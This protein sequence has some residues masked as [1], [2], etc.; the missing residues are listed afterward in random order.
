MIKVKF[1]TIGLLIMLTITSLAF[2]GCP[3]PGSDTGGGP[4]EPAATATPTPDINQRYVIYA[5]DIVADKQPGSA[6]WNVWSIGETLTVTGL[7]SGTFE[8]ADA[9]QLTTLAPAGWF[10]MG[11]E[12]APHDDLS[13]YASGYLIFAIKTTYSHEIQV[14][15][16]SGTWN[17]DSDLST[18]KEVWM[19]LVNGQYGYQ[20]DGNWH[21]VFIPIGAFT[22]IG[23]MDLSDISNAFTL[24]GVTDVLIGQQISLD[25]IH[26]GVNS[27]ATPTP[28]P[29]TE[30]PSPAVPDPFPGLFSETTINLDAGVNGGY[31]SWAQTYTGVTINTA[32]SSEAAD[33]MVSWSYSSTG[34]T[35][36]GGVYAYFSDTGDDGAKT[37]K[38]VTSYNRLVFSIKSTV[39]L[40]YLEVKMEDHDTGVVVHLS[41]YTPTTVYTGWDTYSIPFSDF[42]GVDMTDITVPCG[43]WHPNGWNTGFA[44]TVYI[45]DVH[46][47][48][49]DATP[50]PTPIPTPVTTD[51]VPLQVAGVGDAGSTSTSVKINWGAWGIGAPAG[52]LNNDGWDESLLRYEVVNSISSSDDPDTLTILEVSV[53]ADGIPGFPVTVL[54]GTATEDTDYFVWVRAVN[55]NGNGDWSAM[56]TIHTASSS[57]PPGQPAGFV[58]WTADN[59]G[60]I[61]LACGPNQVDG[62]T[63]VYKLFYATTSSAGGITDPTTEAIEYIFG[64]TAG[65]GNGGAAF[66]F[67]LGGLTPNT[68]Y[69]VWLY[70]Y[71]VPGSLYSPASSITALSQS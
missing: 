8:G 35:Q 24:R 17:D 30:T 13:A 39:T 29:E 71:N 14:G 42:T 65:D 56:V 32:D 68:D 33:G 22:S 28:T 45:D 26:W 21:I 44:G 61:F 51:E 37:P 41:D 11:I 20:N 3:Q 43:F 57:T 2:L 58:G 53:N 69:T 12:V 7:T 5:N 16:Q 38:D 9:N 27:A 10:G 54:N 67:N 1:K 47:E 4:E 60:E 70:Q 48:Y 55:L 59:S 46:F 34:T 15:F 40:T 23:E 63:I 66:G 31:N 25:A 64:S 52:D 6:T 49:I 62:S 18:I 50:T 36:G 19:T